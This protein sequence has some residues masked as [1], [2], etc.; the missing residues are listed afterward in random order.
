MLITSLC[1]AAF[2]YVALEHFTIML[3][4]SLPRNACRRALPVVMQ[5]FQAVNAIKTARRKLIIIDAASAI[6][7]LRTPP[8]NRLEQL[9]GDRA[10]QWSIR[11]NKQWRIC[12]TWTGTDAKDVEIVDYH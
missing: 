8:G 1:L 5:A 3:C 10:G 12:F 11:I 2:E 6:T 7:D 9:K 4:K